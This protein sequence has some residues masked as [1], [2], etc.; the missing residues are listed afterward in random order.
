MK[1]LDALVC[2]TLLHCRPLVEVVMGSWLVE[3]PR[4]LPANKMVVGPGEKHLALGFGLSCK[5]HLILCLCYLTA[6]PII[7]CIEC[8]PGL[9][10]DVAC[11]SAHYLPSSL[12]MI[13]LCNTHMLCLLFLPSHLPLRRYR[14]PRPP[15]LTPCCCRLCQLRNT[16]R[17]VGSIWHDLWPHPTS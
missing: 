6:R 13:T 4:T 15:H 5:I 2:N 8:L 3:Y 7:L 17:S 14:P 16:R 10:S 12:W 11:S 9:T 1:W